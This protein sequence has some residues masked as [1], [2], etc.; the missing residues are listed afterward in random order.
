M[1]LV[2]SLV[3]LVAAMRVRGLD[4]GAC[5]PLADRHAAAAA[6]R[7]LAGHLLLVVLVWR[8]GWV[9]SMITKAAACW[10]WCLSIVDSSITGHLARTS[11]LDVLVLVGEVRMQAVLHTDGILLLKNM[12][13]ACGLRSWPACSACGE[14]PHRDLLSVCGSSAPAPSCW[15]ERRW[16]TSCAAVAVLLAEWRERGSCI[17][18]CLHSNP[19]MA[20]TPATANSFRLR[21]AAA[22]VASGGD[23]SDDGGAAL[24]CRARPA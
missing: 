13:R 20:L 15:D 12:W 21:E 6:R 5:G 11:S 14:R 8:N 19:S 17:T 9:S 24:I 23:A 2:F 18:A 4:R 10:S 22:V 16:Q 3:A 7:E 1:P